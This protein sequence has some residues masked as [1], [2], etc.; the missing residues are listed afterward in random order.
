MDPDMLIRE[1]YRS[2]HTLWRLSREAYASAVGGEPPEDLYSLLQGIADGSGG[3]G[4]APGQSC[5]TNA[6]LVALADGINGS[7]TA[8]G[9]DAL[10][11]E[12]IGGLDTVSQAVEATYRTLTPTPQP[13]TLEATSTA[14]SLEATAVR[15]ALEDTAPL[16][17]AGWTPPPLPATSTLQALAQLVDDAAHPTHPTFMAT[18]LPTNPLPAFVSYAQIPPLGDGDADPAN[19]LPEL[20]TWIDDPAY[21]GLRIADVVAVGWFFLSAV[22]EWDP[23]FE[24]GE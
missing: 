24:G 11:D 21:T 15:E 7:H 9:G 8:T 16:L 12:I 17:I 23:M 6:K 13:A 10:V 4:C 14:M 19:V 22:G 3:G 18:P 2:A 5:V 20:A 1:V